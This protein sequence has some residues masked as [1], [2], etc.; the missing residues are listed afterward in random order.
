MCPVNII[1]VEFSHNFLDILTSILR[2]IQ[3]DAVQEYCDCCL[4][5]AILYLYS[6][7]FMGYADGSFV[8]NPI[9][10]Y[11][12]LAGRGLIRYALPTGNEIL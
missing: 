7:A 11:A 12:H 3:K 2:C 9:T 10:D 4:H 1:I 6:G 8:L 5:L